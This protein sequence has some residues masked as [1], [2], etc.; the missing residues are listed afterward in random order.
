VKP[1]QQPPTSPRLRLFDC[2]TF[3]N[4]FELLEVRLNELSPLVS[5]FVI[6]EAPITFQ[7][8]EKPLY[9]L[10]NRQRFAKFADR[11]RHVVVNDM[12]V[13][14]READHW[15][16]EHHQRNALANAIADA[17]PDDYVMLSDVDEI[18]RASVVRSILDQNAGGPIIHLLELAMFRF[19]LNFREP[20]PWL[21]NGPRLTRRRYVNSF[22]AL[23]NT[24]PPAADPINSF[25]RWLSASM[26]LARPIR[27]NV[28]HDA[29]WHFSS[30]GG[31]EAY[32]EK[33][34]SFSHIEPERR[35]LPDNAMVGV[36][37]RRIGEALKQGPGKTVPV[38]GSFPAFIVDH[39]EQFQ[40]LI[41][42]AAGSR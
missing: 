16:R 11:I 29:G 8:K 7:G 39:V 12:P 24:R 2:F 38:D 25:R 33:L 17:A 42:P 15:R 26:Q 4:E 22:Q 32:A 40:S 20:K 5:Y 37:A 36:A 3:F 9:F 30:L 31:A 19:F 41:Y 34:R 21:R 1:T 35:T 13:G 6:A 14:S 10:E 27:R 28:V 18:P 23:R